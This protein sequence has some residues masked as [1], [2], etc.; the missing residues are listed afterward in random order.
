MENRA[1]T[2]IS[3]VVLALAV[4]GLF[5]FVIISGPEPGLLAIT[6]LAVAQVDDIFL[7]STFETNLTTENLTIRFTTSDTSGHKIL[8]ITDWRINGVSI[9]VINMPFDTRVTSV[10]IGAVRDY[11]TYENNG[12]LGNGL[13]GAAPI[14]INNSVGGGSY[15][16]DGF[17]DYIQLQNNSFP[18]THTIEAWINR[19]GNGP[20]IAKENGVD[21]FEVNFGPDGNVLRYGL[22]FVGCGTWNFLTSPDNLPL[23]NWTYIVG[24][25]DA[26]NSFSQIFVDGVQ[27]NNASRGIC[28]N[29]IYNLTIGRNSD[30]ATAEYTG[31][32]GDVRV[33]DRVLSIKQ[34]VENNASGRPLYTKIVSNETRIG[35]TWSVAVTPTDTV[36]DGTTTLSNNV[37]ICVNPTNG[38]II[39]ESI[40]FCSGIFN[41][42][43]GV[44]IEASDIVVTC[45]GTV[46]NGT[47]AGNG[48]SASNLDNITVEGCTV[49]NYAEGIYFLDSTN[50]IVSNNN[51]SN[52]VG[53]GIR[54]DRVNDSLIY[55]NMIRNNSAGIIFGDTSVRNNITN[56]KILSNSQD[57][58]DIGL[59]VQDFD[60]AADDNIIS[61]NVIANNSRRALLIYQAQSNLIFNNNFS[62]NNVSIRIFSDTFSNVNHEIFN[63]NIIDN[64]FSGISIRK[65]MNNTIS[66][67]TFDNNTADIYAEDLGSNNTLIITN[68]VNEISFEHALINVTDIDNIFINDSIA[69]VNTSAELAMNQSAN[70]TMKV[71]FCPTRLY[72]EPDFNTNYSNVLSQ[73]LH[74]DQVNDAAA[75]GFPGE[76]VNMSQSFNTTLTYNVKQVEIRLSDVRA[77][78]TLDIRNGTDSDPDITGPRIYCSADIIGASGDA[79]NNISMSQPCNLENNTRYWIFLTR[80]AGGAGNLVW[81]VNTGNPYSNGISWKGG[82][83]IGAQDFLFK[84]HYETPVDCDASTIPA[85]TNIQ[86]VDDETT[87]FN[88]DSFS[89]YIGDSCFLPSN[90]EIITQD[91]KLCDETYNFASG[92]S[93]NASQDVV[94]DCNGA[95]LIGDQTSSS[96]GIESRTDADKIFNVT[97]RN[98]VISNYTYGIL[99]QTSSSGLFSGTIWNNTIANNTNSGIRTLKAPGGPFGSG[100]IIGNLTLFNN[101]VYGNGAEGITIARDVGL[102]PENITVFNN[103]FFNNPAG[104]TI[105]GAN[106]VS[107]ENNTF[108]NNSNALALYGLSND[109]FL[110]NVIHNSTQHGIF[111]R[112]IA[113]GTPVSGLFRSENNTLRGGLVINSN[114]SLRINSSINHTISDI[115]LINNSVGIKFEIG[116]TSAGVF[117]GELNISSANSTLR[118]VTFD[119]NTIDII[120]ID[121]FNNSLNTWIIDEGQNQLVFSRARLNITDI[122]NLFI[123]ES[124]VAVN[125]S[126]EPLMNTT[127]N[128]SFVVSSCSLQLFKKAGFNT[129]V[130]ES[131]R[132]A[133]LCTT[134][135]NIVC[136]NNVM[137]FT[138]SS[139]SSITAADFPNITKIFPNAT[140]ET[141][142]INADDINV[143]I[144]K[145]GGNITF[146]VTVEDSDA[147]VLTFKWFI[148]GV[149]K[150]TQVVIKLITDIFNGIFTFGFNTTGEFNVTVVVNDSSNNDTFTFI[151]G[152]QCISPLNVRDLTATTLLCPGTFNVASG[153][154]LVESDIEITCNS[155]ILNGTGSGV[156]FNISSEHNTKYYNP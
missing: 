108:I 138:T 72:S 114:V 49:S 32:I 88:V 91:V 144:V 37:T 132:G 3:I 7:N 117:T 19:T 120:T 14:W 112:A 20:I 102:S 93:I 140:N 43:A 38:Q 18:D 149:L 129:T 75:N 33:Y 125:S 56:N 60:A 61:Y 63:N 41:L 65:S 127:A 105:S 109:V 116:T 9:A 58:I 99:L 110:N 50:A 96:S 15:V 134:C 145:E 123:N 82:N 94:L 11:S 133:S 78:F 25:H 155:T 131:L 52:N 136:V 70:I 39:T 101:I 103:T 146:N 29:T 23:R 54:F 81:A 122:E 107:V 40:T 73:G 80:P 55:G 148:N 47:G 137:N 121:F 115:E 118:N 90:G 51:A 156:G 83:P 128:V 150:F 22:G 53:R 92:I 6:G 64:T 71:N 84:I 57:A 100:P 151:M 16:F 45:Q 34:I 85:C 30:A 1:Q 104:L 66:N 119:N 124:I 44:S 27:V 152:I 5:S 98:C 26:G 21:T 69:A 97:I 67:N 95:R 8:N 130:D 111:I 17:N 68:G 135:S 36:T 59:V 31:T 106:D 77:G 143:T 153:M 35:E 76:L 142:G 24:T 126:A 113:I 89:T 13:P 10:A 46:L 74:L 28:P 62:N 141:Q 86:C 79:W 4:V 42:V 154:R 12:T 2:A 147:D 87:T 48:I 139:F